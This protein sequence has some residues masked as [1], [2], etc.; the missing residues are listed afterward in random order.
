LISDAEAPPGIVDRNNHSLLI[1]DSKMNREGIQG[2]L[3]KFCG[4]TK[5]ESFFHEEFCSVRSA[6]D[7][8]KAERRR[9]P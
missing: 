4:T 8:Q 1:E 9:I 2:L 3:K 6:T 7:E 5:R